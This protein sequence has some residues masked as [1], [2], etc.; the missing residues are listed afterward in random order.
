MSLKRKASVSG[1]ASP[2]PTPIL[3][4][5]SF[6]LD[7]TPKHLH[8][9]TRKRFRNDR[10]DAEVVYAQ[11][12]HHPPVPATDDEG[13]EPE[14]V[15]SPDIVDPRQQTLHKFFRP[16]QTS[17]AQKHSNLPDRQMNNTAQGKPTSWQPQINLSSP[18]TSVGWSTTSPSSQRTRSDMDIDSVSNDI[19]EDL[20]PSITGFGWA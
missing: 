20:Q 17:L 7:E 19:V 11:Q 6:M 10:P 1:L 3:A 16:S 9:R 8:S 13:I 2:S 18:A 12:Q 4:R 5:Q 15:P 14:A